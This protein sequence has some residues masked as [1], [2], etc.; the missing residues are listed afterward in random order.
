LTNTLTPKISCV[1]TSDCELS[2]S[3]DGLESPEGA[4]SFA[5]WNGKT[6]GYPSTPSP[7]GSHFSRLVS[8]SC[9]GHDCETVGSSSS[10]SS[11]SSGASLAESWNGTNLVIVSSPN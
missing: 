5:T 9:A 3:S 11:G 8:V 1:S 2:G 6:W 10:S 4:A 7:K